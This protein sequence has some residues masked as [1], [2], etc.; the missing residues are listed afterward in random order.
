MTDKFSEKPGKTTKNGKKT[1]L[2][3]ECERAFPALI[4]NHARAREPNQA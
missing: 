4:E 1:E 3:P 2:Y